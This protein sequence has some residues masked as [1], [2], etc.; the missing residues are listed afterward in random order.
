MTTMNISLPAEMKAFIEGR[1]AIEGLA[2]ASKDLRTLSREEQRRRAKQ[3]LETQLLEG[4]Q[5]SAVE[6]TR[7]DWA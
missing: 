5:G 6:M 1:M 7:E 4:L 2:S 3:T